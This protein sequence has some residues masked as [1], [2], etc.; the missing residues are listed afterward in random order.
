[1]WFV[2]ILFFTSVMFNKWN[3]TKE[4][5]NLLIFTFYHPFFRIWNL[6]SWFLILEFDE[7]FFTSVDLSQQITLRNYCM[8]HVFHA[9][10]CWGIMVGPGG[11]ICYA[12]C[13]LSQPHP[14]PMFPLSLWRPAICLKYFIYIISV[15]HIGKFPWFVFFCELLQ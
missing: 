7:K 3:W 12:Q 10:V 1:M 8:C 15:A 13:V 9:F 2:N 5:K 11:V 4:F 6:C 14:P